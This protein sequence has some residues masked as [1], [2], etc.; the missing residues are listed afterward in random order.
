VLCKRGRVTSGQFYLQTFTKLQ[1][2]RRPAGSPTATTENLA[3][4]RTPNIFVSQ[5][6]S[7]KPKRFF[8]TQLLVPN[9][10][11]LSNQ[12]TNQATHQA[13]AAKYYSFKKEFS[14]TAPSVKP[15]ISN[16]KCLIPP[17]GLQEASPE[18]KYP[19]KMLAFSHSQSRQQ[20]KK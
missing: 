18:T 1:Y 9:K 17:P 5:I 19:L 4:E 11:N 15:Q 8:T 7:L 6:S 13:S 3:K 14:V 10:P 20:V 2:S 12:S 16:L